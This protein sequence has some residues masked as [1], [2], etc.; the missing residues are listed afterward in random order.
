MFLSIRENK[1]KNLGEVLF[2]LS[3]L[4]GLFKTGKVGCNL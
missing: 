2:Y 3:G 1:K 4:A